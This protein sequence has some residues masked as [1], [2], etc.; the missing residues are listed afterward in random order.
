MVRMSDQRVLVTT[1]LHRFDGKN[2]V[3]W[4]QAPKREK[5][6]HFWTLKNLHSAC[7]AD[8]ASFRSIWV[9]NHPRLYVCTYTVQ[10]LANFF[11]HT[12]S[13]HRESKLCWAKPHLSKCYCTS[14]IPLNKHT[15]LEIQGCKIFQMGKTMLKNSG[16]ENTTFTNLSCLNR[17]IATFFFHKDITACIFATVCLLYFRSQILRCKGQNFQG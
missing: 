6:S 10:Y 11:P 2:R 13:Y 4:M 16:M 15:W 9:R 1:T 5:K 17:S 3:T 8:A 7:T 14:L 12:F